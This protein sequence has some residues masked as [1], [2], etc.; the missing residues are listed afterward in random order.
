MVAILPQAI[1]EG[2][3]VP[4]LSLLPSGRRI[5][6]RSGGSDK[7]S[8]A[9]RLVLRIPENLDLATAAPLLCAG[10]TTYSPL[11]HWKAGTSRRGRRSASSARKC[12]LQFGRRAF[13]LCDKAWAAV[14]SYLPSPFGSERL[15]TLTP[16][17]FSLSEIVPLRDAV[18]TLSGETS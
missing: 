11:R 10:T 9:E 7:I 14:D 5:G 3:A 17:L 4:T 13:W 8:V 12:V 16:A 15:K 2:Q 1:V 6:S 18:S